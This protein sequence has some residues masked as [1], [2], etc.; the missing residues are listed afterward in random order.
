[1]TKLSNGLVIAKIDHRWV[2]F[3]RKYTITILPGSGDGIDSSNESVMMIDWRVPCQIRLQAAK[4][5]R[6]IKTV[7]QTVYR[8]RNERNNLMEAY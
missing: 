3:R 5:R 4:A 2:L 8:P 7:K 1:M 6:R